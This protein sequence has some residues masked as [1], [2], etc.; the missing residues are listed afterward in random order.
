MSLNG[1]RI[2]ITGATSGIGLATA[3]LAAARGA[4]VFLVSRNEEDLRHV[5]GQIGRRGGKAAW[6]R[7]DV[8]V[9]AEVEAAAER[10]IEA[11]G[12]IDAWVNCA[13]TGLYAPVEQSDLADDERLFEVDFWGAVHAT[14][15]ALSHMRRHGGAIVTVSSV[16]ATRS[17]PWQ[18]AYAATQHALKAWTD[19]LRMELRH[20]RVPVR[21]TVLQPGGVDSP[22]HA[23]ARTPFGRQ[24]ILPKP[25]YAPEVVA[26]AVLRCV[27]RPRRDTVLGGSGLVLLEKLAPATGDRLLQRAVA[28]QLRRDAAVQAPGDG[29]HLPP[30]REGRE[31]GSDRRVLRR[32]PLA[33]LALHPILGLLGGAAAVGLLRSR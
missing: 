21:L 2:V 31:R 30:P 6:A 23:H 16:L 4:S 10:A 33:A 1:R 13:A 15:T 29:L 9:R 26:R 18:G 8:A 28:L 19:A 17:V 14:R 12:G 20:D 22:F 24:P 7:A 27:K 32:S 3:R 11:F 25:V 5:A